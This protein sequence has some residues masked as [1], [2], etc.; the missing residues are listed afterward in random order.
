M[1]KQGFELKIVE[2]FGKD[3]TALF[4][5]ESYW[6]ELNWIYSHSINPSRLAPLDTEHTQT[7][8]LHTPFGRN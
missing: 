1:S 4:I 8:I 3:G 7:Q 2:H 6:I 5:R